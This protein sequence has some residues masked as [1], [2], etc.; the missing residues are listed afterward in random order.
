MTSIFAGLNSFVKKMYDSKS[1][2]DLASAVV[3]DMLDLT[4]SRRGYLA[5]KNVRYYL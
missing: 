3:K 5:E 2:S 1:S 4:Q